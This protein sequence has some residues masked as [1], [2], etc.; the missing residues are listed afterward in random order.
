[1]AR[2]DRAADREGP[3][4][5]LDALNDRW[6]RMWPDCPPIGYLFKHRMSD[7]WVRFHSLP[8]GRRYPT[9][10]ADYTEVLRRH[11]EVLAE[12]V[13][14]EIYLITVEYSPDDLA[15]GT[16]P[17][18]VGLHPNAVAWLRVRPDP[19][20]PDYQL[21]VSRQVFA[22][23]DLDALLRYVADD[24]ASEVVIADVGL[25]WL[26]HPYD[27]GADVILPSTRER[28]S[29]GE[30]FAGWLSTRPDGL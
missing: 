15:A 25:R 6:Q 10:A 12:L 24:R 14:G 21:H 29:L 11:N 30:R 8:L 22:P 9:D 16:E 27:G 3:E 18:H 28:D 17:I 20:D 23:G 1:M 13:H 5:D 7:R 4:I 19:D 26:Y 2:R